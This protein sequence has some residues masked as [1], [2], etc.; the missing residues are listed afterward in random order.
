M[1]EQD[2]RRHQFGEDP[3]WNESWYFDFA[4]ADGSVGGY[5]RLGLVPAA[6]RAWFWAYLVRDGQP[7]VAVRDHDVPLPGARSLEVRSEGLWSELVCETPFEHWSV[8][9]EAFAVAL[10]HPADA[11]RGE[12][13]ER[14]PLGFDLEWEATA[15]HYPYP[16]ITR[17]EQACVV[18][19]A[20]LV[21]EERLDI[22]AAGERDHSWGPRDWWA[23]PWCWTAGRLEDGTA[24]HA[25]RPGQAPFTPGFVVAPGSRQPVA[26][27]GF[28]VEET[29]GP[30][31]LPAGA[32]MS[33]HPGDGPALDLDVIPTGHAPVLLEAPDGRVSRFPRALC[34]FRAADGRVGTGWTEWLQPPEASAPPGPA[35]RVDR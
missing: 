23:I 33:L 18:H 7:L 2:E 19:G 12:R 14:V 24:F 29:L 8:G 9:L 35:T 22:D 34:Q 10:G 5:L 13:G 4:A 1:R 30:E 32:A 20:V 15:D 11:Y 16:V 21:G 6:E 27:A 28:T 26:I 3:H 17:Y 31:G 25:V